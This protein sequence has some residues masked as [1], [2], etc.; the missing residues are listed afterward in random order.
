ML[1]RY[2]YSKEGIIGSVKALERM[3]NA[4]FIQS[5]ETMHENDGDMLLSDYRSLINLLG[6][7][8][9][10]KSSLE[11]GGEVIGDDNN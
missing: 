3:C 1:V 10:I 4:D 6:T 11:R 8:R 5:L 2:D 7:L 9:L